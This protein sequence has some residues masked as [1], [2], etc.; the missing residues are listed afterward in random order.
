MREPNRNSPAHDVGHP[1]AQKGRCGARKSRRGKMDERF[2]PAALQLSQ[3]VTAAAPPNNGNRTV[4]QIDSPGVD[5][6]YVAQERRL[7]CLCVT[8][9]ELWIWMGN[10]G[11]E[12]HG[13]CVKKFEMVLWALCGF[14]GAAVCGRL[15]PGNRRATL[16]RSIANRWASFTRRGRGRGIRVLNGKTILQLEMTRRSGQVRHTFARKTFGTKCGLYGFRLHGL[17][18][19]DFISGM[20]HPR[21]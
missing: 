8:E 14:V 13:R 12:N 19:L 20:E 21:R 10:E 18:T 7:F 5:H 17:W 1:E 9:Q 11:E 4:C 15:L 3:L 16:S 6:L 2:I